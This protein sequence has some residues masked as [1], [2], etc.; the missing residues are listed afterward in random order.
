M[1]DFS[2]NKQTN[3]NSPAIDAVYAL[4]QVRATLTIEDFAQHIADHG[5]AYDRGDIAAILYKVV[6]CLRE[7]V[8]LGNQV[9]LGDLGTFGPSVSSAGFKKSGKKAEDFTADDIKVVTIRWRRGTAIKN[10][11]QEAEL[12]HVVSRKEQ[13]TGVKDV[14][15]NLVNTAQSGSGTGM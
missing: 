3:T 8:L 1:I 13:A 12:N 6:A 5:A 9:E 4:P 15:K 7:Q 2:I 14:R 11:R 10:M